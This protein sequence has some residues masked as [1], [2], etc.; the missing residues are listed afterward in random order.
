M[1]AHH[2]QFIPRGVL[3]GAGLLI[4][5]TITL[6]GVVQ[7]QKRNDPS[8]ES[9]LFANATLVHE[10]FIQFPVNAEGDLSQVVDANT[11][12]VIDELIESDGFIRTVLMSMSFDRR[13]EGVADDPIYRL[14]R[15]D[16]SRVSLEDPTTGVIINLGAFGYQNK[17]VFE[18]FLPSFEAAQ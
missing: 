14:V 3:I 5:A 1:S 11:G 9:E 18:R 2:Q 10:R 17:S 15:W 8:A 6:V 4:A 7:Y 16:D 13:R 12:E